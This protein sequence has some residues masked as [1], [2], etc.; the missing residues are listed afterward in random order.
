MGAAHTLARRFSWP[1]NILWKDD[2]K[3]RRFTIMLSELDI[4]VAADA[5]GKYLTRPEQVRALEDHRKGNEWKTTKWTGRD[6]DVIWLKGLNHAE[7]FDTKKDRKMVI[8]IAL[9]YS[10]GQNRHIE[11]RS[12]EFADFVEK[13]LLFKASPARFA[14]VFSLDKTLEWE[15]R[16]IG[17]SSSITANGSLK[18][19]SS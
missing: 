12:D 8:D 5:I 2:L 19:H 18:R 9:N 14:S 13:S 6:L 17:G 3:G 10:T 7:V 1:D 15:D 11:E 16:Q 4:I